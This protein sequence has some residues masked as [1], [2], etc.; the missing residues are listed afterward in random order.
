MEDCC[1]EVRRTPPLKPFNFFHNVN[2]SS[3]AYEAQQILREGTVDLRRMT[4]VL[5]NQ[6]VW[7]RAIGSQPFMT[8]DYL[9]GVFVGGRGYGGEVQGRPE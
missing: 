4:R 3:Q 5:D 6:R 8:Q 9:P 2:K 1:E 7:N